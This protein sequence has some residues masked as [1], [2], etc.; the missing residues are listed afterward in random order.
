MVILKV[1]ATTALSA[2]PPVA[3]EDHPPDLARDRHTP[4]SR[5]G[6]LAFLSIEQH[7]SPV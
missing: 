5:F 7:M 2:F 6:S 4:T 3:L 1:K